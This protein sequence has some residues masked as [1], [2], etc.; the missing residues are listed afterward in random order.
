MDRLRVCKKLSF[1]LAV[2]FS[3]SSLEVKNSP[4]STIR[5]SSL[6]FPVRKMIWKE[7]KRE[8]ERERG[9]TQGN[10]EIQDKT[11]KYRRGRREILQKNGK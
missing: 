9:E 10:C 4:F 6:L 11:F 3:F 8:R 1:T 7:R 5:L 2:F